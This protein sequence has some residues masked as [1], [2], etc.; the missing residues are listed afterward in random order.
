[1]PILCEFNTAS[2]RSHSN[3]CSDTRATVNFPRTFVALPR[4]PHGF[5]SLDI[6]KNANI[7]AKSTIKSFTRHWA[8]CHITAWSDTT[9]YG[10]VDHIF[11]LA[12]NNLDFLTGEW[13][14]Y[15]KSE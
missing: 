3:P 5:R 8:D 7:R 14:L 1:M 2:V 4:V 11:V 15:E 6:S 9:P 13:V 10:G 12:P